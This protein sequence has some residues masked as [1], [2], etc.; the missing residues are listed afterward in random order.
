MIVKVPAS[1][2][3][4]GPGFDCLGIALKLYNRIDFEKS[5]RLLITGCDAR[6]CG[7]CG[8]GSH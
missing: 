7:A 1:T 3:N 8:R 6:Y 4:L 2:A 5:D